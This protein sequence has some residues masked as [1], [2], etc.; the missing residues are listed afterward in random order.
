VA[1]PS[2]DPVIGSFRSGRLETSVGPEGLATA[3]YSRCGL[4]RYRLSRVWDPGLPRA[5][6]LLLNPSTATAFALDPTLRRVFRYARD[7]GMG[8]FE[9]VNIFALRSTDPAEL[10]RSAEPVGVL[11][12][13]AIR[14]AC[15]AA[16][17]R[18]AGWG[19]HGSHRGRGEHVR[20]L[21]SAEGLDLSVLRLTKEGHPGHP[22]Y[23]PSSLRPVSWSE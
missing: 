4:Y 9:V 2:P 5:L 19:V 6:F 14:A 18:V 20:K 21:L 3:T 13:R 22:L 8:S 11:N 15:A 10:Y 23:L 7:W 17:T 12:D 16:D 1:P